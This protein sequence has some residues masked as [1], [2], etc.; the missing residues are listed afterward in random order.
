[1]TLAITLTVAAAVLTGAALT[2]S[3]LLRR[4][5]TAPDLGLYLIHREMR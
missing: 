3:I 1:M 2:A 4:T 5:D